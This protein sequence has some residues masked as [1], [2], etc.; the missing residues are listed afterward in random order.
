MTP[1]N[2]TPKPPPE[3][4][5]AAGRALVWLALAALLA[6]LS[7]LAAELYLT[8]LGLPLDDS[9]IHLQ[10]AR[11]LAAGQ[12]LSYQGGELVTGSTAPLWTALLSLLFYLPGSVL[13]W[14]KLLGIACFLFTVHAT[15]RLGREVG[16][17]HGLALLAAGFALATEWLVWS[18]L[19]GMEILLFTGLGT[20]GMVLHLRERRTPGRLALSLPVLAVATLARPEGGLL[21][22]LALA[23][24]LLILRPEADRLRLA[25]PDWRSLAAGLALA[26]AVL[27]PVALF[28]LAV[29]GSPLPTT[30][31]AKAGSVR[32]LLPQLPYVHAV[33]AIFLLPQPYMVLCAGA[34]ILALAS[35][36]GTP[37][38]RGLLPA[39]WL[40]ALPLAYSTLSP[41]GAGVVAGNF[42]RYLFPLF[43]P[44][45][46]L[47]VLGLAG[48]LPLVR[49]L[50]ALPLGPRRLPAAA[51]LALLLLAWPTVTSLARGAARHAQTVANVED[52]DV[53]M[54]RWLAR[55]LDPAAVLAVNDIGAL[56]YLLPNRVLDLAGIVHPQVHRHL[57]RARERG[58]PWQ[59]GILAFLGEGRPDYLIVFPAWFPGLLGEGT[60][61]TPLF[62]LPIP[63]NITMGDDRLVVAATPWTRHP[64]DLSRKEP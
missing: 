48:V 12:G 14:V 43:P 15:Y 5:P 55:R 20:W 61:F 13:A 49:R 10:F 24:R 16:L 35:R 7:Y 29:G 40:L 64:L 2:P 22:L 39:L 33:L 8:G 60:G 51:G 42:G 6:P 52:S 54:A 23:D 47:G 21:L 50:P 9:W 19:S 31:G 36:L 34:G 58:R 38:D 30:F 17:E 62:E 41:A 3:R 45:L 18:A 37:R 25:A 56:K 32:S 63:D 57:A 26:A 59:E 4:P 46:V 1:A 11:N 44:L 53:R 27:L 28:Y